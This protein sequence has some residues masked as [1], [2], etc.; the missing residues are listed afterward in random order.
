MGTNASGNQSGDSAATHD[1][2]N[3]GQSED[4]ENSL[5]GQGTSDRET[6]E[7]IVEAEGD[8]PVPP[9]DEPE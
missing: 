3:S 9:A 6:L 4:I 7:D 2:V 5:A 8:S 1:V